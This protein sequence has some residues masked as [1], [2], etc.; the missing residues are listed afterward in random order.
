[1]TYIS[2]NYLDFEIILVK[3]VVV[4]VV[5]VV[6]VRCYQLPDGVPNSHYALLTAFNHRILTMLFDNNK[7][8]CIK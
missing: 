5:V 6:V 2:K 7:G 4:V 3:F 1:M 8:D